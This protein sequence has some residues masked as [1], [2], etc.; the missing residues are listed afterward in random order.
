MANSEENSGAGKDPRL[1]IPEVLRRPVPKP[2]ALKDYER[3]ERA[4]KKSRVSDE[5]KQATGWAIAMDFVW[6]FAAAGLI[7]WAIQKW[8]WP[9]AAPWP[10]LVGLL[11]G[12]VA[13]MVRFIREAIK[14]NQ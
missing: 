9:A 14:A 8:A 5:A 6:T 13:G 10:L 12:I 1:E 7:G 11:V 2:E 4:A 3:A